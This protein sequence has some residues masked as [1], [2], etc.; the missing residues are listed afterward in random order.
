[1][2]SRLTGILCVAT[3]ALAAGDGVITSTKASKDAPLSADPNSAF[4]KSAPAVFATGDT[5]GK[6]VSGHRTEIRSRWT[7]DNA[8]FLFIC[9][10]EELYPKPDTV[11]A[12]ETNKMWNWD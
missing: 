11:T 7:N 8:Y 2:K 3:L 9:P 5:M 1:M 4:W 6:E 10:Y 12:K